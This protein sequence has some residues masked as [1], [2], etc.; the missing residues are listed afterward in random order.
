MT[1]RMTTE[2]QLMHDRLTALVGA[3]HGGQMQWSELVPVLI[4][5]LDRIEALE[6]RLDQAS[7]E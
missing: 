6:R 7:E 3:H 2:R 1:E 4:A 5:L